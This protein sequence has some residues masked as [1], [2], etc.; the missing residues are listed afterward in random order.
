MS[1]ATARVGYNY[2]LTKRHHA[3]CGNSS[4]AG[5]VSIFASPIFPM[6]GLRLPL[7][8]SLSCHLSACVNLL[9]CSGFFVVG[10]GCIAEMGTIGKPLHCCLYCITRA[11]KLMRAVAQSGTKVPI[12]STLTQKV[13]GPI[14]REQP[15][16]EASPHDLLKKRQRQEARL[17]IQFPVPRKEDGIWFAA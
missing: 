13:N 14:A 12:S 15:C 7:L 1:Y 3:S 16:V 5:A 8:L 6:C 9:F 2:K 11:N 10:K 4:C 17:N